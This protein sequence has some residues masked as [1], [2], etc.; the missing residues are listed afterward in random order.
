MTSF[1]SSYLSFG[2]SETS[3]MALPET[4]KQWTT[5]QDGLDK[6]QFGEGKVPQ[7]QEGEV[8][9]KINAVGLNYRDTEGKFIL[10][11]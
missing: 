10:L 7:P 8:L 1:I 11:Y 9:V 6:L 3:N 2:K 5:G 4:N